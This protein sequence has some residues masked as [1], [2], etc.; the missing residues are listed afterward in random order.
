MNDIV[1]ER[2]STAIAN[3]QERL[4]AEVAG[5]SE[6][7]NAW[8]DGLA[9]RGRRIQ[10][11]ELV[12]LYAAE[13]GL[14]RNVP[15]LER[16]IREQKPYMRTVLN[17]L[18]RAHDLLGAYLIAPN[19]EV[20]LQDDD[21]PI[22]RP[23][24]LLEITSI[25]EDFGEN[26]VSLRQFDSRLVIDVLLPLTANVIE[27]DAGTPAI[28]LT[29]DASDFL[30]KWLNL[31]GEWRR[32]EELAF[33]ISL[34]GK[35]AVIELGSE[36]LEFLPREESALNGFH[37]IG[38]D[39]FQM[40]SAIAGQQWQ[41]LHTSPAGAILRPIEEFATSANRL[42]AAVVVA[43]AMAFLSLF[44]FQNSRFQKLMAQD[45]ERS[46]KEL[47]RQSELLLAILESS[48]DWIVLRNAN[49]EVAYC[50]PAMTE[51]M[52]SNSQVI[53]TIFKGPRNRT[54]DV[55]EIE[56]G[57]LNKTIDVQH[58][59]LE[60]MGNM[61]LVVARD[62]TE[63]VN[64]HRQHALL[65]EQIIR[66]LSQAVELVDPYLKGHALRME[67][68]CGKLAEELMLDE[69]EQLAVKKAAVLSQIGKIFI[70]K[71][72]VAKHGRH[73]KSEE[74][75][76]RT[77]IEHAKKVLE[78]IDFGMPVVATIGSMHERLD[79]SGYPQGRQG[80]EIDLSS[81][82]AAVADVFCA[83]TWPRSYR[84]AKS[85]KEIHAILQDQGHRYDADVVSAL[86]SLVREKRL[87]DLKPRKDKVE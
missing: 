40:A 86:G 61:E 36:G 20:I 31:S 82:I 71:E 14:A 54:T 2:R 77:H 64:R 39:R 12:A 74:A 75:I 9:N 81:R 65:L 23:E 46:A 53:E 52:Q 84:S 1:D 70:P 19:R 79:G 6:T 49:G 25:A 47:H 27:A 44:W 8:L 57:N 62:L 10:R 24:L 45:L 73:N 30:S 76:M 37:R 83:R 42:L 21:A 29:S 51:I 4:S 34:S 33:N 80:H 17:E 87:E 58:Q 7:L 66:A 16:A 15:E 22:L 59:I 3:L 13:A 72:I 56:N 63:L 38:S 55:L 67:T 78:P 48:S 50:N 28:L 5:K 43:V 85:Q 18:S 69:G 41:L 35:S 60:F 68:L 26:Q 32:G 11:S